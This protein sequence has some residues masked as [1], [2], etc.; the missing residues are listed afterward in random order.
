[1]SSDRSSRSRRSATLRQLVP[2][3]L[4]VLAYGISVAASWY[5]STTAT[6][7]VEA[8]ARTEFV[9]DAQSTR[10]QI[11]ARLDAYF[12]IV[13]A[14][15]VLVSADNEINSA[16]FRRFVAG[17]ELRERY[18]GLD[19]IGFVQCV[20]RSRIRALLRSVSL[21]GT[22]LT[23]WPEGER[24][25]YCPTVLLE[26]AEAGNTSSL[27]YD[28]RM[29]PALT[30]AMAQARDTAQPVLSARLANLPVWQNGRRGP[31][32]L[33]IP[34]FRL[35]AAIGGVES[36][37]RALIGYV[38]SPLHTEEL[39]AA[40]V[41]STGSTIAFDVYDGATATPDALLG[42]TPAPEPS[43]YQIAE[44]VPLASR[45]WLVVTRSINEAVG[46]VPQVARQTLFGGVVLSFM[47]FLV[48]AAQ[49][50]A[51]ETA[52]RHE[53]ELRASAAAIRES[54]AEAQAANRA[55]DE[56]LATLSHELRTPLNVVLGWVSMLRRGSL[57]ENRQAEAL[58]IIERNAR[59]Q[60]ELIDDLL[61]VSRIVT[62]KLRVQ[63]QPLS[64]TPIVEAVAESLRPGAEAKGV[65]LET[66]SEPEAPVIRADPDRLRQIV[67][68]LISNA[69][70]FTPAGGQVVVEL[71]SSGA[72]VKVTVSDTGIG[73]PADFLPHVFERFRQAD[74]STTRAHG[75]VGLG[76]AIV[77][78][79]MELH[80][81]A[82]EAT[83]PGPDRGST[84][85]VTFPMA[86]GAAI[87]TGVAVSPDRT[88]A[89]ARLDGV[90]VLVVDDDASTRDL[91]SEALASSGARVRTVDSARHALQQ[92]EADGADVIVSD[93]AMPVEDGFWFMQQVR[94]LPGDAGR[95]PAVALTA[96]ARSEDRQRAIESGYQLHFAKPVQLGEL[97]QGLAALL[98]R[99]DWGLGAGD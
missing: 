95:T 33:F 51:W 7:T 15:A 47:L 69:I 37:R 25:V 81:G 34:V 74:S 94:A 23:L 86:A 88:A 1:V 64:P 21:D 28:L 79:L 77:R 32:V 48:T 6:A 53:D 99:R 61:D 24:D 57:R 10:R 98:Q 73:I 66:R 40:I 20:G 43:R 90:R 89:G 35:G 3:G 78:H 76:L 29:E 83:S 87:S 67:W 5:L 13:R 11:Q 22:P 85:T 55:K 93:I 84:F 56:F 96:L 27:G 70:K 59:Q 62:G 58:D 4:F 17:L 60:A 12:E 36:R 2:Y 30:E 92:L 38:F 50:R 71:A 91:L 18:P 41:P 75:G 65:K 52:A 97:Q 45:E 14:G 31:V 8:R 16:E 68:N 54:E 82:I 39:L 63:L 9:T 49:V 19:G 44:T 26:P 46:E 72:H 80:G 42:G